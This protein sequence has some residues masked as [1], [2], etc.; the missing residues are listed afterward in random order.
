VRKKNPI[1][2][3]IGFQKQFQHTYLVTILYASSI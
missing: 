2:A 1:D 3:G